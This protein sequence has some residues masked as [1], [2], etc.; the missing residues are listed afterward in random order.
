MATQMYGKSPDIH[1]R[2][3]FNKFRMMTMLEEG[4]KEN[5][6]WRDT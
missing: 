5:G 6:L 1:M 3:V 2:M 4:R